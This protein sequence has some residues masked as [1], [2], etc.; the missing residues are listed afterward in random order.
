MVDTVTGFTAQRMKL[1]EDSAIISGSVVGD[2]LILT[3]YDTT[4]INAGNVRGPVGPMNPDGNP[5][6]TIIMGGWTIAP[7]GYLLLNGYLIINGAITYDDLADIYPNW[8]VGNNLQLPNA[9]GAVPLQKTPTGV[10]SGS[11]IHQLTEHQLAPHTHSVPSHTH[12]GPSHDHY[13]SGG[14]GWADRDHVHDVNL[15][16]GYSNQDL[17][18][19]FATPAAGFYTGVDNDNSGYLDSDSASIIAG[20]RVGNSNMHT[21][22]IS[23]YT[24]GISSNHL[25]AI[26]AWSELSGTNQTGPSGTDETGSTGSNQNID[27]TPKHLS[28]RYA[29]KT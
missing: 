3:R 16:S 7:T 13:I 25:H 1:I 5:R 27:H 14:T 2:N 23:G 15:N 17:V 12:A 22:A 21:H 19:R 24:G 11:M 8:V 28:I 18:T 29:V 20:M 9:D 10:V 26:E 4:T 6:G